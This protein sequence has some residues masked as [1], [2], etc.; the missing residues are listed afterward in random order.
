M[1]QQKLRARKQQQHTDD[2]HSYEQIVRTHELTTARP[3]RS[4]S[5][6]LE[7]YDGYVSDTAAFHLD[8]DEV[9][10]RRPLH[11]QTPN[12]NSE[13]NYHTMTTTTVTSKERPFVAVRRAHEQS[14]QGYNVSFYVLLYVKSQ[15]LY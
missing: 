6:A 10:Y 2:R 3:A 7:R 13:R 8:R 1:Q 14:K 11:V 9:D 5:S 12:R 15:S 4:R